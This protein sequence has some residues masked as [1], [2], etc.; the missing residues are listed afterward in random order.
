M[1]LVYLFVMIPPVV[2]GGLYAFKE[3]LKES[4]EISIKNLK[5]DE[6]ADNYLN[7]LI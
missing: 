2:M 6:E 5:N 7:T 4:Y 1:G 3:V